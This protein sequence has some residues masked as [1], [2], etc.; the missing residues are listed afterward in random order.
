MKYAFS[1]RSMAASA[2][3]ICIAACV[4]I[5]LPPQGYTLVWNDEFSTL[6]IDDG[7]GNAPW[8]YESGLPLGEIINYYGY[9]GLVGQDGTTLNIPL[10]IIADSGTL[11]MQ[12]IP[13]PCQYLCWADGLPFISAGMHNK[14][15]VN[16]F[17]GYIEFR[18]RVKLEE[19]MH[20]WVGLFCIDGVPWEEV[21]M[22]ETSGKKDGVNGKTWA[23]EDM[24]QAVTCGANSYNGWWV[25]STGG[26]LYDVHPEN[27][28]TYGL[29]WGDDS[30]QW[31]FDGTE[32]N[33]CPSKGYFDYPMKFD[34][35]MDI[36][37]G[38]WC[39]TPD[40]TVTFPLHMEFD[41][42]RYYKKP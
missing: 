7:S 25:P 32:W 22:C 17:K 28:H 18:Y 26:A 15:S 36:V 41:Y 37:N 8:T 29:L 38:G 6:S 2:Y 14:N 16:F 30:L 33:S 12:T 27:W 11:L 35:H 34:I 21:E 5:A 1:L 19:G 31:F 24:Q 10:H 40:S 13:T 3:L 9:K 39:G 42:F 20:P 23:P 4:A